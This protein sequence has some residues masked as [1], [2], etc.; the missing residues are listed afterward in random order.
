MDSTI[1]FIIIFF[2]ILSLL[3]LVHVRVNKSFKIEASWVAVALAPAVLWLVLSG[4][5]TELT[6]LGVNFKVRE[7]SSKGFSLRNEGT[8][9]QPESIS[10]AEK[11][12]SS[13]IDD[14]RRRGTEALSFQLERTGYVNSVIEE[15]FEALPDLRYVVFIHKNGKFHALASASDVF[16]EMKNNQLDLAGQIRSG[17]ISAIPNL[18]TE[19]VQ[20]TASR[21]AALQLMESKGS[22]EL[23]VTDENGMFVGVLDRD[24]LTSSIVADLITR[25]ITD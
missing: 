1:W 6:F 2:A 23:P 10:T 13:L 20:S 17:D 22:A 12:A 21:G 24:K 9:I 14:F 8:K 4:Q 25:Q 7:V 16:A 15:Y 3:S 18:R 11:G 5:L 19:A